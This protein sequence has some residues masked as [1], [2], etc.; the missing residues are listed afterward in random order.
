MGF[1]VER[2]ADGRNFHTI[3]FVASLAADGN[4]SDRLDYTFD[5]KAPLAGLNHYRLKQVDRDGK[6]AYSKVVSLS[7]SRDNGTAIYPNPAG[8]TATIDVA[9]VHEIRVYDAAGRQLEVP[10]SHNTS[11]S[12]L[13]TAS[14][15]DGLYAVWVISPAGSR[16]YKMTVKQ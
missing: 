3:G 16:V 11:G 14:L 4:S 15:P 13:Q 10:V 7:F 8:A 1:D 2:S 6:Q 12:V 9:G 5:D